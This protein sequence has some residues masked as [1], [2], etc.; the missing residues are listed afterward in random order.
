MLMR[1]MK[2]LLTFSSALILSCAPPFPP[3]IIAPACPIL[4]PGG[5]VIPA[6]NDTTGLAFPPY[7]IIRTLC[8]KNV[9]I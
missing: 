3:E 5:A 9:S 2:L 1:Y 6:I 4:R 7:N 8:N